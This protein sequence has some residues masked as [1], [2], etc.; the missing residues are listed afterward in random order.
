MNVHAR[1]AHII[2]MVHVEDA[3]EKEWYHALVVVLPQIV[4]LL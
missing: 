3:L 1:I 4:V 2:Q